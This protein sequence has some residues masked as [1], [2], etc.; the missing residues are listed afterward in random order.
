MG[1]TDEEVIN[2]IVA[3]YDVDINTFEKDLYD[4]KNRLESHNLSK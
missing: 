4:F 1:K 3:A 2:E